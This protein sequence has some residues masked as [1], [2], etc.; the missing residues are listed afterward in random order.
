MDASVRFERITLGKGLAA[1]STN[2]GALPRVEAQ[3]LAHVRF[4]VESLATLGAL[5]GLL[6]EGAQHRKHITN[7]QKHTNDQAADR[8]RQ[9]VRVVTGK[10]QTPG[11]SKKKRERERERSGF[12]AT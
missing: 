6:A 7:T 1:L 9:S 5:E 4:L 12:T 10:R 3:V 8:K 11:T 2:E